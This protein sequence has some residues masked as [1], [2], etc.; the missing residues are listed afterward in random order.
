M[1]ELI[2]ATIF[3]GVYAA[4]TND[5]LEEYYNTEGFSEEEREFIV[6]SYLNENP[7][8]AYTFINAEPHV[9]AQMIIKIME[10]VEEGMKQN[11]AKWWKV[12]SDRTV[13]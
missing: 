10:D 9:K 6:T 1:L 5:K 4:R 2:I 11:P 13:V 3:G 7:E 12:R 8:E